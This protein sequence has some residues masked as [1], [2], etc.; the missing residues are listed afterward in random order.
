MVVVVAHLRSLACLRTSD[1]LLG[2]R[3]LER[4]RGCQRL[5]RP[6]LAQHVT[7]LHSNSKTRLIRQ[8]EGKEAEADA[9]EDKAPPAPPP[10]FAN[11]PW[12]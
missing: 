6:L 7:L 2:Q 1:H 5:G 11:A 12:P 4:V 3:L 10:P 9:E 8:D